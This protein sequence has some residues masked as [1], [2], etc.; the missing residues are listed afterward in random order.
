MA[1]PRHSLVAFCVCMQDRMKVIIQQQHSQTAV[2]ACN[3]SLPPHAPPQSPPLSFSM[4]AASDISFRTRCQALA[5]LPLHRVQKISSSRCCRCLDLQRWLLLRSR[6]QMTLMQ[7]GEGM[8]ECSPLMSQAM[9]HAMVSPHAVATT[10]KGMWPRLDLCNGGCWWECVCI[11]MFTGMHASCSPRS[12]SH[13]YPCALLSPHAHR[14]REHAHTCVCACAHTQSC[15]PP[16]I[17][18]HHNQL[19]RFRHARKGRMPATFVM[20][21]HLCELCSL[22]RMPSARP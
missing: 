22:L 3:A 19:M 8:W 21:V 5:A 12:H 10:H 1:A 6:A 2:N 14:K 17:H 15:T 16:C 13:G 11:F 7:Q 20:T 9:L 4:C 18:Q